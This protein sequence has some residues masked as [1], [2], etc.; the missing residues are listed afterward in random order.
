M[1]IGN[2]YIYDPII[3]LAF[4]KCQWIGKAGVHHLSHCAAVH[5]LRYAGCGPASPVDEARPKTYCKYNGSV[6]CPILKFLHKEVGNH[7]GWQRMCGHSRHLF[8]ET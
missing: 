2:L 4:T 1:W 7:M 8:L 5:I 6:D 3:L